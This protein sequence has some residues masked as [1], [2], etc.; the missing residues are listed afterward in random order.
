[1]YGAGDVHPAVVLV[2][3]LDPRGEG[4]GH[5]GSVPIVDFGGSIR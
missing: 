2:G 5:H 1:V 4:G 3:A